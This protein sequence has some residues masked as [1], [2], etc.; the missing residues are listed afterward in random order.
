VECGAID[1]S[2]EAASP[3]Y[4]PTGVEG[5]AGSLSASERDVNEILCQK[6]E[7]PFYPKEAAKPQNGILGFEKRRPKPA[8]A[9]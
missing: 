2:A 1:G 9:I 3:G 8:C 7:K 6:V 4:G 5:G